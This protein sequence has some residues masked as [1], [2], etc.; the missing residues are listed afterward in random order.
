MKGES[1]GNGLT[2]RTIGSAKSQSCGSSSR[3]PAKMCGCGETVLLLKATTAKNK[4]RLFYRCRNWA[5]TSTCNYFE[6]HEEEVSEI[7]GKREGLDLCLESDIVV[8]DQKKKIQKL[9]RKLQEEKKYGK[10]MLFVLKTAAE[11]L[12]D[13]GGLKLNFA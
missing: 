4:G 7:E 5:S 8:L 6:W 12:V 9:K 11:N 3:L 13:F 1:G 10:V 2:Q